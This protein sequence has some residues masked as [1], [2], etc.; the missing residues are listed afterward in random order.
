[1]QK[2]LL[3]GLGAAGAAAAAVTTGVVLNRGQKAEPPTFAR[4]APDTICIESSVQL[5]D[6][7]T[8]D[9]LTA[10]QYAALRD[11]PVIDADGAPV[12]LSLTGPQ[13][14]ARVV[15]NCVEY[16]AL[17]VE[18]WYAESGAD[19]RREEYF[20]RACGALALLVKADPARSTHF[21][22]GKADVADVRSIARER[23]FSIGEDADGRP[24][25]VSKVEDG[26]WKVASPANEAVVYEIAHADFTG[27]GL[28][29][30]LAYVSIGAVGG[31]ARG[32]SI[33]LMEKPSAGGPCTFKAQ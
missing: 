20:L 30:I 24:A 19:M 3:I 32:G 10:A 33:G 1:M 2:R 28:G 23:A 11:R 17:R 7:M 6:G 25:E 18:E 22:G 16:D 9:C 5:V 29:E 15:R 12:E 27:D 21:A 14:G 8:Q 13:A 26:V 31:T 4:T